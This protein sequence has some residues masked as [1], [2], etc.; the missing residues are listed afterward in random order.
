MFA[1]VILEK[2]LR[3]EKLVKRWLDTE[4]I[5]IDEISMLS[6]RTFEIIHFVAQ[7]VRKSKRP[8]G[9]VQLVA[10]GDFKQLPPIKSAI[11]PGRYCFESQI[12]EETSPHCLFLNEVLRQ[13]GPEYLLMLNEIADGVCSLETAQFIKWLSRPI[14]REK[15]KDPTAHIPEI[16]SHNDD[17]DFVN[18][19][20]LNQINKE[21]R[22]FVAQDSGI[23]SKSKQV[24]AAHTLQLKIG[25]RV[26]LIAKINDCLTNGEIGK[27]IKFADEGLPVVSFP[28][29]GLTHKVDKVVW[30]VYDMDDFTKVTAERYQVPLKLAWAF[31]VHKAQG[32][33]LEAAKV[34]VSGIFAPGHLYVALSRVRCREAIQV[35]GFNR[36]KITAL[37]E[38]VKEFYSQCNGSKQILPDPACCDGNTEQLIED[39]SDNVDLLDGVNDFDDILSE[40]QVREI[41]EITQ[42]FFAN[43]NGIDEQSEEEGIDL[44]EVLEGLNFEGDLSQPPEGFN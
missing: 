34:N 5:I 44:R 33:T 13:T 19:R 10:C 23:H 11:D 17:V 27:V 42:S 35:V 21:V 32:M 2:V 26:M 25:A 15:L 30:K 18:I 22:V 4:L 37:P 6:L 24:P 12:W 38:S 43:E 14:D 40:E 1:Q 41:D 31:K 9:G 8:F 36:S 3:N 7:G 29:V 20:Y 16:Y 39:S 28:E